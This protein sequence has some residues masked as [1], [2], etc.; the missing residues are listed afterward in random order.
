M[1]TI[2]DFRPD[3]VIVGY[4]KEIIHIEEDAVILPVEYLE[5]A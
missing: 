4:W 3:G 5:A 1:I 2:S